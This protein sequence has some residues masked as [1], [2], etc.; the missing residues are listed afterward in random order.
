MLATR[1]ALGSVARGRSLGSAA[2]SLRRM[3]TVSDAALDKKVSFY[4]MRF[5]TLLS[6]DDAPLIFLAH[7]LPVIRI[8]TLL[9]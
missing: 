8:L 5:F 3:A 9:S 7:R 6:G 1:Q 2:T 4:R